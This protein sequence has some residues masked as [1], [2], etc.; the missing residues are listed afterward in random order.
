MKFDVTVGFEIVIEGEKIG[1]F[2]KE[3]GV[4]SFEIGFIE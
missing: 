4:D 3:F 2:S 1:H